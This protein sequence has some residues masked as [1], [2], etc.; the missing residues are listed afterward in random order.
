MRLGKRRRASGPPTT[1]KW[2]NL[3]SSPLC[4][5]SHDPRIEPPSYL[6]VER[7]EHEQL[8]KSQ[9]RCARENYFAK[10]LGKRRGP[11]IKAIVDVRRQQRFLFGFDF[12]RTN[13]H[14]K[15]LHAVQDW[16]PLRPA[17]VPMLKFSFFCLRADGGVSLQIRVEG[18]SRQA[19]GEAQNR[20]RHHEAVP[21]GHFSFC[22]PILWSQEHRHPVTD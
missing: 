17:F 14:I 3:R 7:Y 6:L 18:A 20:Q 15:R 1:R 4:T 21:K 10:E 16:R 12:I 8:D 22:V 2:A 13:R 11:I 5:L 19:D 9:P